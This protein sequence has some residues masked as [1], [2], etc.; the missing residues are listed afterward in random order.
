MSPK[1]STYLL[2]KAIERGK[3]EREELRLHLID[4]AFNALYKLSLTVPF[5]E[6]YLFGSIAKPYGF[7]RGSDIDIGFIGL[8]DEYFF[9]TMSFLSR[10]LGVD[11]DIIQLEG[12]RLE[13]K[14]KREGIKWTRK[15]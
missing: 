14:V 9:K 2:D 11:V 1:V 13:E 8:K 10:E 3:K 15:D 12:H 7:V 6:A 4:N 5:I